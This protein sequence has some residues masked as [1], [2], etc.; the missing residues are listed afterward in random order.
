MLVLS[1][2]PDE[3][4]AFPQLGIHVRV[5][6]V[7]G[8]A[9]KVG[10]QAPDD[11]RIIRGE[12]E[13]RPASFGDSSSEQVKL[14][15]REQLHEL[16]NQLNCLSLA[17]KLFQRQREANIESASETTLSIIYERFEKLRAQFSKTPSS[18]DN[19][20]MKETCRTLLVE[21]DSNERELLAGFLRMSGYQVDTAR[22]GIEALEYLASQPDCNL[23]L[24]DMCMP[25]MD[26]RSTIKTI[27][28]NPKFNDLKVFA[29]SG[30]EPAQFGVEMGPK[31]VDCWFAKPLDPEKLVSEMHRAVSKLMSS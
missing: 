25:R 8:N 12:L 30:T 10:V 17:V 20:V 21:D 27:R 2:R 15:T 18:P 9:V 5:L 4:F 14:L 3:Y 16:N 1:R 23:V 11:I 19:P 24:L 29:V 31:G 28:E 6:E 7:R 13:S 26:G 22:D